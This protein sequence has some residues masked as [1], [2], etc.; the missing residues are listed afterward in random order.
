MISPKLIKITSNFL[1]PGIVFILLLS[2]M[3][4]STTTYYNGEAVEIKSSSIMG[5]FGEDFEKLVLDDIKNNYAGLQLLFPRNDPASS[6]NLASL[7]QEQCAKDI[8]AKSKKDELL[9]WK[10]SVSIG[11]RSFL[12]Y[13][14]VANIMYDEKTLKAVNIAY[15]CKINELFGKK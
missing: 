9:I 13:F 5:K 8:I 15:N 14:E 6:V 12:C 11:K 7:L 4:C 2:A 3:G 1:L 10:Y